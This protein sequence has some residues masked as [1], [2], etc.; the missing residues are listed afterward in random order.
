MLNQ[1]K[2]LVLCKKKSSK[3]QLALQQFQIQPTVRI[4]Q[5]FNSALQKAGSDQFEDV[6]CAS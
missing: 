3:T 2:L 4:C 5:Y 1:W 6:I